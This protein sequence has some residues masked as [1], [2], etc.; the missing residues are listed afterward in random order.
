[1]TSMVRLVR[2]TGFRLALVHAGIFTVVIAALFGT[3]YWATSI[4]AHNQLTESIRLEGYELLG[5]ARRK[6]T[7]DIATTITSRLLASGE[8]NLAYLL[9]DPHGRKIAGN[10]APVDLDPGWH[11]LRRPADGALG[12]PDEDDP[13]L[14]QATAMPDGSMLVVGA[15][16]HPHAELLEWIIAAFMWAGGAAV[17]VALAGGLALGLSLSR[18]VETMNVTVSRIIDGDLGERLAAR[19][20]GDEFD[21]LASQ[22]NRMLDRI[23]SLMDGLRQVSSDIA[24]DLRTPLGRLRQHLERTRGHAS[25]LGEYELATDHAIQETDSILVTFGA[26]LRVAQIESGAKRQGFADVDLSDVAQRIEEA[27]GPVAE[28]QG[29]RFIA[30][31]QPSLLIRGDADLLT[32]AFANLVE[33]ALCHTPP[34]TPVDLIVQQS[35]DSIIAG[36]ADRGPGIPE[37]ER[38]HVLQRFGR[39]DRSRSTPGS[40]LGLS[41]VAAV[42]ELHDA[43]IH[44]SDNRPGLRA[45]LEFR[46]PR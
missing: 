24:H 11:M 4:Y 26:L 14:V 19:P 18:R 37:G 8:P 34:G 9:K 31:V 41:L 42:A 15:D 45:E 13:I 1:M 22:L 27:Y 43:T 35:G 16:T 32:Q 30:S 6:G 17:L 12:S 36:V 10:L 40:G 33:N 2:T 25:T 5:E 39:L 44:L 23:Q 38:G 28:D 46:R 7:S 20:N 21:R 29:R 3:V